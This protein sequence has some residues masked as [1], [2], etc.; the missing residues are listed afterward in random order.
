VQVAT[1]LL[2]NPQNRRESRGSG[3]I[4]LSEPARISVTWRR[5]APQGIRHRISQRESFY[6]PVSL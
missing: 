4:L 6:L 3:L 5:R 1:A 2:K